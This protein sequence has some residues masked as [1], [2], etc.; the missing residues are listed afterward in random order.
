MPRVAPRGRAGRVEGHGRRAAAG[1]YLVGS[2]HQSPELLGVVAE[3][4]AGQVP[5]DAAEV[6]I[7]DEEADFLQREDP[8]ARQQRAAAV[9]EAIEVDKLVDAGRLDQRDAGGLGED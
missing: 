8:L 2:L 7:V 1:G 5:L 9:V 4:R 3:Q 6:A